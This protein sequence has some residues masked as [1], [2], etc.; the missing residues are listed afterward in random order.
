MVTD[1]EYEQTVT[2]GVL[3]GPSL[4]GPVP[5]GT[6]SLALDSAARVVGG[7]QWIEQRLFEI[8]GGWVASE[9]DPGARLLFDTTSRQHAWHAELLAQCLPGSGQLDRALLTVPPSPEVDHLLSSLGRP[10]S[11]DPSSPQSGRPPGPG[12]AG[13]TLHRLVAAGRVVLPRLVA[14][15][16]HHLS[17]AVPVTD[18]PVIRVLRLVMRDD[19]EAWQTTEAMIQALVRRP[20]DVA[21]VTAHQQ[22]LEQ[23]VAGSGVGL[24]PWPDS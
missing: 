20:H 18:A 6:E 17:R 7:Y 2:S 19:I 24:V 16:G 13:G 8:L 12:G 23:M 5:A 3:S 10:S 21:V 9:A 22:E 11:E 1:A 4:E 14:G 15:Y